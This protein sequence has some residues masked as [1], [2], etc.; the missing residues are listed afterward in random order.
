MNELNKKVHA[1]SSVMS[2]PQE[3][4]QILSHKIIIFAAFCQCGL[5]MAPG[6]FNFLCVGQSSLINK[7][8]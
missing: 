2:S 8:N 1:L 5:H 4:T 3:F 6:A 7:I